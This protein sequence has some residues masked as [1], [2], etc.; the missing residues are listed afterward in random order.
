MGTVVIN[1][2]GVNN[3]TEN[4]VVFLVELMDVGYLN[5]D[6]NWERRIQD[7]VFIESGNFVGGI[8]AVF[9]EIPGGVLAAIAPHLRPDIIVYRKVSLHMIE[10][11]VL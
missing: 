2:E 5:R 7:G 10:E 1:D 11:V 8:P 4:E 6:S 9:D 3:R